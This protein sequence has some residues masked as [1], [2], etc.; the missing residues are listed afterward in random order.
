M[1]IKGKVA[2]VGVS[3]T[4]SWYM[5]DLSPLDMMAKSAKRAL[6]E[7]GIDKSE[8]DGLFSAS[9]YYYMPTLS[10]GEY[11]GITPRYTDSTTVGG[12]SFVSFLMHA[13]AAISSGLC[14]VALICYGSSQR[15]DF[16]KVTSMSEK[17]PYEDLM[18]VLYPLS[19]YALAAQRHMAEYGTTNEQLAEVAVASRKW[20]ALTPKATKTEPITIQ[21]VLNSPMI[22]SPLHKMDCCLVTDGG[23][24]VVLTSA[25]R[26]KS[27]KQKPVYLLGAGES[28]FHRSISS[29]PNLTE[30]AA[31]PSGED[32][33]K[34]AGVTQADV[35]LLMLYDA[36]TINVILFLEDLGFCPKG[37]GGAFVS[38]G[39]IAPGGQLAVNTNG[40][41]LS[42][43]HP[44]MFGIFLIIEAVRQLRRDAGERQLEKCDIALVHGNGGTLSSQATAILSNQSS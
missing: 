20:A 6:D 16:G 11:L 26:A 36:F 42:Y 12:S 5:P 19:S 39:R 30:T 7:A 3:E 4:D 32:A 29:M 8:V 38:N 10:L 35:D 9:S 21:D 22:S 14:N 15:S 25:E 17:N 13:A 24:A 37:E 23:G 40:G 34:M 2:I 18:G 28:H 27:L 1:S 41:G 44:G 43:C 31:K 33:F